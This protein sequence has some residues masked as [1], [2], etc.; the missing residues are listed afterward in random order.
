MQGSIRPIRFEPV[1]IAVWGFLSKLWIH[2]CAAST[3]LEAEIIFKLPRQPDGV[4]KRNDAK[5]S[6]LEVDQLPV[7]WDAPNRP[8]DDHERDGN[9]KFSEHLMWI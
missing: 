8:A 5:D 6:K 9:A 1:K 4:E 7:K 3:L 2:L